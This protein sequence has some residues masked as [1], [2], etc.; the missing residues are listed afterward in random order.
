MTIQWSAL[1]KYQ[2]GRSRSPGF[3]AKPIAISG[4]VQARVDATAKRTDRSRVLWGSELTRLDCCLCYFQLGQIL[5]AFTDRRIDKSFATNIILL[6]LN[7]DEWNAQSFAESRCRAFHR[8]WS[9]EKS[10]PLVNRQLT[11]GTF[12]RNMVSLLKT[13]MRRCKDLARCLTTICRWL[14]SRRQRERN[15]M[16]ENETRRAITVKLLSGG[17]WRSLLLAVLLLAVVRRSLEL[18]T[19]ANV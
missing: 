6:G 4:F 8:H 16:P 13:S 5:T 7:Y 15:C 17:T 11:L 12:A 9:K 2:H 19:L 3:L 1:R 14:R 18:G 10:E